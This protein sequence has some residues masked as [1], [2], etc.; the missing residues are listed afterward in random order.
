MKIKHQMQIAKPV[1]VKFSDLVNGSHFRLPK[2]EQVMLKVYFNADEYGC[3]LDTGKL[4]PVAE[5]TVV[6]LVTPK[7]FTGKF[8][9]VY[10]D[11]K[12]E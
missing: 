6:V 4:M 10:E 3:Y 11:Y 5:D 7:S 8:E 9:I 12:E 1:M 2:A